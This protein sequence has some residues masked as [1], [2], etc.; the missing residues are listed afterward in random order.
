MRQVSIMFYAEAAQRGWPG[1][2]RQQQARIEHI[3]EATIPAER[4][5]ERE[6]VSRC[7]A[8]RTIGVQQIDRAVGV[9]AIPGD[10]LA[11]S[12]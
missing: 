7:G 6:C 2:R 1:A 3:Q 8:G 10:R 11:I 4:F 9:D 12:I 5:F